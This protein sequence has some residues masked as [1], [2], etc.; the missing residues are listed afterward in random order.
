MLLELLPE[1]VEAIEDR[2]FK[3]PSP[4]MGDRTSAPEEFVG[5]DRVMMVCS[6]A[7]LTD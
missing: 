4:D 5:E 3:I 7:E 6:S 1:M 2:K